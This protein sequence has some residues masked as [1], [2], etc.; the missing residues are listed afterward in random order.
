MDRRQDDMVFKDAILIKSGGA[1]IEV[2]VNVI[3]ESLKN[4]DGV[5]PPD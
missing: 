3:R 2:H 4:K 5:V 1:N